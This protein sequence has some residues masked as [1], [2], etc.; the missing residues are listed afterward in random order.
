MESVAEYTKRP[1]LSITAADLGHQPVDIELNLLRFFNNA[2]A[3]DA[4]VLLDEADVYLERR[5]NHEM[6]RNSI[7]SS[8][9]HQN[10]VP[11]LTECTE[12]FLVFLRALDYFEGILFFTTNRVGH[13]D[14]AFLSRIHVS[15]G[16]KALDDK[17]CEQIWETF[18][19]KLRSD[20]KNGAPRIEYE[21]DAKEYVRKNDA[22][23][24]LE[25]NGRETRNGRLPVPFVAFLPFRCL[26]S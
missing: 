1:L 22:V 16:Y 5:S 3:W 9:A 14:E 6:G 2:R 21:Y 15:I 4:I 7:I 11:G 18:F 25:W 17:A 26:Q 23:R 13:F 20:H 8:E 24:K 12:S 10:L 19:K